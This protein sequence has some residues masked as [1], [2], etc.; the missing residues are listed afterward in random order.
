MQGPVKKRRA[1]PVSGV[2]VSQVAPDIAVGE[3]GRPSGAGGVGPSRTAQHKATI[4]AAAK[5]AALEAGAPYD[6]PTEESE[7]DRTDHYRKCSNLQ[8]NWKTSMLG[9]QNRY[10][11]M[12][13]T[14]LDRIKKKAD[15]EQADMQAEINESW[16]SHACSNLRDAESVVSEDSFT[17]QPDGVVTYYGKEYV[18]ELRLPLWKC[19]CCSQS[20][21]P[22]PI[23]FG[24][25]PSTPITA[26]V[27]YDLRLM[28]QYMDEG[29]REGLS[30]T[31]GLREHPRTVCIRYCHQFL[32][33]RILSMQ[34]FLKRTLASVSIG[35][36]R[37]WK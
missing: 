10:Y 14:N 16:R 18:F 30:I 36:A 17:M 11:E 5:R 19:T 26:H 4:S 28:Q 31:G 27:W 6:D 3:S 35:G 34:R 37:Q 29:P 7:G 24:C 2:Y 20:F 15:L 9:L 23:D 21:S 13:P 1:A 8:A 32:Y 25:F 12:L 22:H 33:I